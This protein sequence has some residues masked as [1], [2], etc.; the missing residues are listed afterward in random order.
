MADDD[1]QRVLERVEF[2]ARRCEEHINL[3][4]RQFLPGKGCPEAPE[5]FP[6]DQPRQARGE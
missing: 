5:G 4:F 6:D 2:L 1:V 3:E